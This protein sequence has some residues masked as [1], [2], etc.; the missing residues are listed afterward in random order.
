MDLLDRL[1][2]LKKK[3]ISKFAPGSVEIVF[4]YNEKYMRNEIGELP[5][6]IIITPEE[7]KKKKSV[8]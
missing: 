7:K 2:L 6:F 4:E 8:N 5:T 3:K 1:E